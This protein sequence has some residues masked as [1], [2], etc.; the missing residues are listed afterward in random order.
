M[1][2]GYSEHVEAAMSLWADILRHENAYDDD[3]RQDGDTWTVIAWELDEE[4]IPGFPNKEI[5]LAVVRAIR[6]G[7]QKGSDAASYS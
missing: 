6:Q 7:Y 2:S 5:A 3:I 1:N 4:E